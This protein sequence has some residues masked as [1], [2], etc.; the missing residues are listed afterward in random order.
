MI[1]LLRNIYSYKRYCV[2]TCTEKSNNFR[3]WC[4][5]YV[6]MA[7]RYFVITQQ[8]IRLLVTVTLHIVFFVLLVTKIKFNSSTWEVVFIP[9]F[10]FDFFALVYTIIYLIQYCLKKINDWE[11][12]EEA[13]QSVLIT[14]LPVE[15]TELPALFFVA[16]GLCLKITA[17]VLLVVHLN[18]QIGRPFVPGILFCLLFAEIWGAFIYYSLSPHTIRTARL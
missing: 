16:I 2:Q 8:V 6:K 11:N 13:D 1:S 7:S 18:G 4:S 15:S 12:S 10:I 5:A 3:L 9:L 17:Q 14:F